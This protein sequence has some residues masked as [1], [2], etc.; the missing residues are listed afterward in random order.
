MPAAL[1]LA[2]AA[3]VVGT[4]GCEPKPQSPLA[5]GVVYLVPIGHPTPEA[6]ERAR[7][8][9]E[10]QTQRMVV[11]KPSMQL[12]RLARVSGGYRAGDVLDELLI[13]APEDA[14]RVVGV[15][16]APLR[17]AHNDSVIGYARTGER[18]IVYSTDEL[19]V[20]STE[21]GR[22]RRVRRIVAHELGHTFGALHCDAVCVMRDTH[23]AHDIDL[24]PDHFCPAHQATL[25]QGLAAR[26][27]DPDT[28]AQ[29]GAERMRL[30]RWSEAAQVYRDLGRVRPQDARARTSLGIALMASG[31]L[32]AA[33]ESF[34]T[35]SVLEP[36]APQPY[37][38]RAVLYA[39]GRST[40]R[41]PAYLEA[42]VSRD[43]DRLRAHRA[44]GILYQDLLAD[45]ARAAHHF[46]A[47]VLSGGRDEDV[48]GRLVFLNAPATMV[49][50][51][52]ETIIA[53]WDPERGLLLARATPHKTPLETF[54]RP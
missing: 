25:T 3:A 22:R 10:G 38:A 53:R 46:E 43:P 9:L 27:D 30:G 54:S 23:S 28:L 44:A 32:A 34:E 21:A 11:T 12:P 51:E 5:I 41:A 7:W 18:A 17:D 31:Q 42:A 37:Y 36:K 14:F 39:A 8:A 49:F 29:L 48:I 13:D 16:D 45:P 1:W 20:V 4:L 33:E 35:A 50:Y 26:V 47:H 6:I 40:H 24:L 52:P 15:T 2:L 19:P